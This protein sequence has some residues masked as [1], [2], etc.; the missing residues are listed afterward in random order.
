MKVLSLEVRRQIINDWDAGAG[1]RQQIADR[2][3]VSLGMVKKLLA[4]RKKI[5]DLAPQHHRCGRKSILSQQDLNWLRAALE[6]RQQ[7]TLKHLCRSY[8][9]PC[10]IMTMSRGLHKVRADRKQTVNSR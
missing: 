6:N 10:S 7:P 1:T 9:K 4:Q 8:K 2:Y 5:G 3:G